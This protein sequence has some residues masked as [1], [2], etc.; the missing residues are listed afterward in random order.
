[1]DLTSAVACQICINR[2]RSKKKM[3]KGKARNAG[4]LDH[5][6]NDKVAGRNILDANGHEKTTTHASHK[7]PTSKDCRK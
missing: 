6:G 5:Y 4:N 1:M 3:Y 2:R 7:G